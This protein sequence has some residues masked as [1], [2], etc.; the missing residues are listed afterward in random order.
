MVQCIVNL[1]MIISKQVNNYFNSFLSE[2][3]KVWEEMSHQQ[4]P[5]SGIEA[6]RT[7]CDIVQFAEHNNFH[8][9]C[10]HF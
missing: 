8:S 4:F 2:I 7:F 6:V 9:H 5:D 10:A 1:S 3:T